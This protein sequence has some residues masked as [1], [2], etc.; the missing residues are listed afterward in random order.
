[1]PVDQRSARV[2]PLLTEGKV[3][4]KRTPS[5]AGRID[6]LG[7]AFRVEGDFQRQGAT[8][9]VT[10]LGGEGESWRYS[11]KLPNGGFVGLGMGDKAWVE[12]SLPKRYEGDNVVAFTI[13]Q[14]LESARDL[15]AEAQ[16][17]C[18]PRDDGSIFDRSKLVRLDA[19]RDFDN[20]RAIAPILDGLASVPRGKREKVRR[21]A[22]AQRSKAETL[23]VGPRAWH[24][25]LYDKHAETSSAPEGRLRCEARMHYEQLTNQRAKENNYVMRQMADITNEKVQALTR[26]TFERCAF[27]REVSAVGAVAEEVFALDMSPSKKATLWA[28]LTAPGF[29][30]MV[31]RKTFYEYRNLAAKLGLVPGDFFG[32]TDAP[33]RTRLDFDSGT[34]VRRVAA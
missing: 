17:F 4:K 32:E 18:T 25:T 7:F 29:G 5:P 13:P 10:N 19:V 3:G 30:S 11:H 26:E 8:A 15:Y 2:F 6:T 22:D 20:V 24:S 34:E 16:Q 14:A 28:Y 31:N 1:M 21:F 27:D 23:T 9:Q 12:A 33:L